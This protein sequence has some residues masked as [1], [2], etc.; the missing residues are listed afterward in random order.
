[1][2][3]PQHIAWLLEGVESWNERHRLIPDK[4]YQFRPDFEDADLSQFFRDAGMLED[5]RHI[6]LAGTDLLGANLTNANLNLANLTDADL[7][8]ADLTNASLWNTRLNRTNL[9]FAKLTGANLGSS[10]PWQARLYPDLPRSPEQHAEETTRLSSISDLLPRIQSLKDRYDPWTEFYF[11]GEWSSKW[12]L[13]PAIAR[14]DLAPVESQ[15]LVDLVSRRPEDFNGLNSALAKWVLA[16]HHGLPTRFL[17][18]TSNPLVAL[19]HAC[20]TNAKHLAPAGDGQIHIFA[21]PRHLVKTFDSDT[22]SILANFARLPS[23]KQEALLGKTHYLQTTRIRSENEYPTAMRLLYQLIRQ[24]KPY[25]EENIEPTVFYGVYAVEPQRSSERIRAQS[26]AFL[27]SAF[28][29]RFEREEILKWNDETPV[30]AHYRWTVAADDKQD[31][32]KELR[33]LDIRRESLFPS[34]DTAAES[35]IE[36]YI[37][38]KN[39]VES[40]Q[41]IRSKFVDS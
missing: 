12:K 13:R 8:L 27:V 28:H 32:I 30:Y 14:G 11:R 19:F 33:S 29:E 6:P 1:M 16:Q 3:N 15:M 10:K 31:I 35:V 21:I 24:E 20:D 39:R 36:S 41:Q 2:A 5:G 34:L 7:Q 18:V 38:I 37:T 23:L 25:F 40:M 22:V 17:D 26:G 4:G 9:H